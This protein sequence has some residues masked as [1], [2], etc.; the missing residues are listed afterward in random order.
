MTGIGSLGPVPRS[1][2]PTLAPT[3]AAPALAGKALPTNTWW[4]SALVGNYT[5]ALWAFPIVAKAA[6]DGL[7]LSAPVPNASQNTVIAGADPALTIGGPL[8][9]VTVTG[10]GDFSVDLSLQTSASA[11]TT[12]IAQGNPFVPVRVPAGTLPISLAAATSVTDADGADLPTGESIT[13]DR[14]RV[15]SLG[16]QWVLAASQPVRW[17]RTDR[18][19]EASAVS[20]LTYVFSP[21]PESGPSD[22]P[23][24]V[25]AATHH[26]VTNTDSTLTRGSG[27]VTQQLRWQGATSTGVVAVLPHQR[28]LLGSHV[29]TVDGH[30][31]TARGQ[32]TLVQAD[33]LTMKYPLPGLLPGIP[34]IP[35]TAANRTALQ[36]DLT[37]DLAAP[38]SEDA[39]S[40]YGPKALSRLATML[41]IAERIGDASAAS[42]IMAKLRPR[43]VDWFTYT[44]PQDKHW[45]AYD[46]TW[47]GI[48][49]HP[50]E[51]GNSDYYNDHNFH[52]GYLIAAAAA[53]AEADPQFATSYGSVVDLLVDDIAGADG[54]SAAAASFP[55]FRV[56]SPYEGHSI[57]SGFPTA[58][59]GANQE[60][61]SEAVNAWAAVAQWGMATNQQKL[62]D[63]GVNRYALEADS[64]RTYWLGESGRLWPAAYAHDTAGIVWGSKVDFAT[65]FDGRPGFVIGIQLLPFTFA[66]LYRTDAAA[67]AQRTATVEQSG[68]TPVWPDLF[69]M[70]DALAD[71]AGALAR[72]TPSLP[73]EGGNSRSFTLYWL[74]TLN[75]LGHPRADI[76]ASSPYGFAFGDDGALHLAAINPTA[77]PIAVTWRTKNGHKVGS[78]RLAPGTASTT[79]GR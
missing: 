55:P 71:P 2:R 18:G 67:A 10:Y 77:S 63:A 31:E 39:G 26:P 40:Y 29:K 73:I 52:Y 9:R 64:A 6:A 74:L 42:A 3:G 44:G 48:V 51:F 13:S 24:R 45:L 20:A 30:Y 54:S 1:E 5:S 27:E 36:A 25:V 38:D 8:K 12:V 15:E 14:L 23:D 37:S 75:A 68:G 50:S 46:S 69:L 21:V 32:L 58:P 19:V 78:V 47:G 16:Q 41:Q 34:Q 33:D 43:L 59:D 22:W 60:S 35:L 28:A 4:L 65:F 66:S 61:S 53:V 17:Q 76:F 56:F 62:I 49:A 72:L 70:D 57:A 7:E 79:A 11:M